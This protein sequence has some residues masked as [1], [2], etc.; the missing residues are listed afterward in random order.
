MPKNGRELTT[1]RIRQMEIINDKFNEYVD[2]RFN[3][4]V[5][6]QLFKPVR[7]AFV[8]GFS[9]CFSYMINDVGEGPK[10][11]AYE[12]MGRLGEDVKKNLKEVLT[13]HL[14]ERFKNE[15]S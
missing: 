8:L 2:A 5:P 12:K 3:S 1:E 10:E 6:E 14:M 9:A 11:E 7:E 13:K 4:N 15:N